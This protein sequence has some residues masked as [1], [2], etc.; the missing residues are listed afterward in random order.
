MSL[1]ISEMLNETQ[2]EDVSR[3][4]K[5]GHT[6]QRGDTYLDPK[7]AQQAEPTFLQ[8]AAFRDAIH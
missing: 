1:W 5:R 8:R 7:A 3:A 4:W 6:A 2:R